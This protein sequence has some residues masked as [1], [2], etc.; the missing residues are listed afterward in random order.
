[1][2]S[3]TMTDPSTVVEL[4]LVNYGMCFEIWLTF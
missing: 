4:F 1:M 2:I 3:Q